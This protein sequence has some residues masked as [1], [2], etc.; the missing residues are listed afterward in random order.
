MGRAFEYRKARKLKRWGTMAK[1]FTKIGKEISIA[2]KQ[3]G[4]DPHTNSRLRAAIQN[5]KSANM[6]KDNVERAIKKASTKE[7]K[8]YKEIVYEGYA[9]F[10]IAMI[11][12]TATDNPVRTVGNVRYY[13]SKHGGSL[14]TTGCVEYMF[15]HKCNFKV[16]MKEGIDLEELE[17]EMIDLDV[18]E[19]FEDEGHIMIYGEF[20]SFGP[21]QKYLE[22]HEFEIDSSGF[23]RIPQE[24]KSLTEEQMVQVDKMLAKFEEDE[25]VTNVFHN[26]Q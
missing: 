14:G 9:P 17:L 21:I 20:E 3:G 11:I 24:T 10:G 7:Q 12:E 6:P 15:E 4:P 5:A 1:T 26:I 25:D 19:V 13:F 18:H 23:E 8:D 16:K 2:V 22:D